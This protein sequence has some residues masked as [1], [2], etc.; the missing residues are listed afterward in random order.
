MA[1]ARGDELVIIGSGQDH[2]SFAA[3]LAESG[4]ANVR[5]LSSYTTDRPLLRRWLSA[6]DIYITASRL[7]G[8]PV[9]PIEAM[10]CRLPVIATDAQGLPDILAGGEA[11]GGL[12][13]A[14]DD[15]A[16][17]A[18]AIERLRTDPALRDRL[19]AA[20]RNRIEDHF[21]IEAVGRSLAKLLA[22]ALPAVKPPA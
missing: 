11:S 1:A 3:L 17:L 18:S 20:A 10:A 12:M 9:A 7:E 4:L 14:R 22:G 13:V 5:W 19:A 8:M 6:A 16:G 2:D 15:V 21:S